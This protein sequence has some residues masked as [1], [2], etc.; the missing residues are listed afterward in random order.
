MTVKTIMTAGSYVR[1]VANAAPGIRYS[2][3]WAGDDWSKLPKPDKPPLRSPVQ[4]DKQ[5]RRRLSRE[6]LANNRTAI[7]AYKAEMLSWRKRVVRRQRERR[8]EDHNYTVTSQTVLNDTMTVQNIYYPFIKSEGTWQGLFGGGSFIFP[9]LDADTDY[10]LMSKLKTRIIGSEFNLGVFLAESHESLVMIFNAANRLQLAL[11]SA[12][13]GRW[14]A[15]VR[16]LRPKGSA[17]KDVRHFYTKGRTTASNWLELSWGWL[18]LLSDL[19]AGAETLAHMTSSPY[20]KKIR[21]TALKVGTANDN[22]SPGVKSQDPTGTRAFGFSASRKQIIARLREVDVPQLIG[23]TDVASIAWELLPMSAIAD[24]AIPIGNY[25][26]ARGVASALQGTFVTTVATSGWITKM[27]LIPGTAYVYVTQPAV[28]NNRWYEATRTV[29]TSL[30]VPKPS[31][32]PFGEM[33][34][35]KRTANVVSLLTLLG[36]GKG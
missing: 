9:T 4:L 1:G 13:K 33:L 31:I 22:T 19:Q 27:D 7:D 6:I 36:S 12:R 3:S 21:V 28:Y 17:S 10:R 23:L 20:E 34:S 14:G 35:W 25:L 32:K 26:A 16:A 2:K 5:G 18:P 30:S 11:R 24:Y 29:S 8:Y 15:A